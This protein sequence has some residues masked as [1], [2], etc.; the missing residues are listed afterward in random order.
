MGGD[1]ADLAKAK[2]GTYVPTDAAASE[3]R[4]IGN[5]KAKAER[6][7][8]S[9]VE[10]LHTSIEK[11]MTDAVT[12]AEKK[13]ELAVQR[14]DL[15]AARWAMVMEKQ[16]IKITLL[17]ANVAAK[18]RAKDLEL[19]MVNTAGMDPE[20]KAWYVHQRKAILMEAAAPTAPPSA[21]PTPATTATVTPTSTPSSSTSTTSTTTTQTQPST[22]PPLESEAIPEPSCTV[23]GL[24][25]LVI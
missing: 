5:K 19:L 24:D 20:V 10:R 6:A 16:D 15:A 12:N 3:G 17:K 7:A 25:E 11:C 9:G 23:E 18:K 1:R 14:E 2:N 4:P 21:I 13:A 22:Q 8:A